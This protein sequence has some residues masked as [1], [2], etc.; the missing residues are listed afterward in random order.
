MDNTARFT[1][2]ADVYAKARPG[3]APEL[4]DK[5]CGWAGL[6]CNSTVADIGAGTGIF[7]AQLA[8]TGARVIAVEPNDDM[9]THA[10]LRF[11]GADNVIVQGGTAEGT[12]IEA[13]SVDLVTA[14]QAFHWFDGEVFREECLRILRG[15]AP[16]A[17]VWN[18]RV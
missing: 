6:G 13:G 3:Y 10:E 5:L 12:G 11:D 9:R 16:V 17:L 18:M 1:G 4:I 2:R 7:S 14:A 8:T 15:G